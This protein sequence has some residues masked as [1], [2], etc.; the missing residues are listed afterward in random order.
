MRFCLLHVPGYL[1]VAGEKSLGWTWLANEQVTER[2]FSRH[3]GY[4]SWAQF[5]AGGFVVCGCS[6]LVGH[7]EGGG[8]CCLFWGQ[9]CEVQQGVSKRK[10]LVR[11]RCSHKWGS[12]N[13]ILIDS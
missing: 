7:E 2:G 13:I 5:K 1:I 12:S 6:G 11:Q 4:L 3:H 8:R 10:V 9:Y